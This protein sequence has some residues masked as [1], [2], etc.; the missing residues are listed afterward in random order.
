MRVLRP[1]FISSG[2]YLTDTT[3]T[4]ASSALVVW[5][6]AVAVRWSPSNGCRV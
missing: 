4:S 2:S 6:P 5:V 3:S 1:S